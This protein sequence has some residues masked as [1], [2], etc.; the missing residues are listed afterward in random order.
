MLELTRQAMLHNENK[1]LWLEL[2]RGKIDT[3]DWT[4]ADVCGGTGAISRWLLKAVPCAKG[5]VIDSDDGLLKVGHYKATEEG[6]LD[7]LSFI[8]TDARQITLEDGCV[9]TS[10]IHGALDIVSNGRRVITEMYRLASK[11]V[12]VMSPIIEF[13]T[14]FNEASPT[15]LE[16]DI[17]ALE[18]KLMGQGEAEL[19]LP[20]NTTDRVSWQSVPKIMD[21][22]GFEKLCVRGIMVTLDL[23][24]MS[25]KHYFSYRTI[26]CQE[27]ER[28]VKNFAVK[29]KENMCQD[30]QA[31]ISL[32]R[33]R[34]DSL[35][36]QHRRGVRN[37]QWEGGP[38]IVWIGDK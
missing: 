14:P 8:S 10:F 36:S 30:I 31:L 2:L 21:T 4:F 32:Y 1:S 16:L 26:E 35:I 19:T 17:R 6:I 9:H 33:K 13:K 23:E 12:V 25:H 15:E 27:L 20:L 3:K 29:A 5:V 22:L 24:E 28:L 38:I 18:C 37:F 7:R 11:R 34:S